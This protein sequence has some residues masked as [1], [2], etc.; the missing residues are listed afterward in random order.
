MQID[1]HHGVTYVVARLAGFEHDAASII[2]YSAQYVDDATNDGFIQFDNG[3]MFSR[4]SSAHKMLDYRNFEQLANYRVWIPFHFL[5][6]NGGLPAGQDPPG[7]FI[8]KLICRP[9][10]YVAQEMVK[11]AIDRRHLP[12]ALHRLGITMHVYVDTWAHQGFAGVNHR[13]NDA[14][15]LIDGDGKP[16]RSL[17]DRLK[18]YFVN[19]ALPLGHG[20]VLSHPDKPFLRWGYFNGRGEQITRN[21]PKDF[22]EAANQMCRALQ[23]YIAGNPEA[24]VPGLPEPD[25]TLI[26]LLLENITDDNGHVRHQKWQSAIADGKFSFGQAEINYI[27]KG[28]GSWK[29][30]SLGTEKA[31]DRGDE[32]FLYH[33]SFLTSNW[34][35]FHDALEAHHFYIVHDLLPKYGICVA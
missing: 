14:R 17:M 7:N 21:N 34:K 18:N 13:V 30:Q 6:G 8:E 20:A 31:I 35:L 26:A 32:K 33:P 11:E 22:L 12:Y 28:K 19:E 27:P 29:F 4:M 3:A 25:K 5:P 1:F 15:N 10:S 2:A 16:D 9:N 24:Q 23:R